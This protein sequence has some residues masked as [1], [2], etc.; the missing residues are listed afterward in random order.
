MALLNM[1]TA[2]QDIYT[3]IAAAPIISP[4]G[5]C[6]PRWFAADAAFKDPAELIITPDH[7]IFRMFYSQ[8]IPLEQLGVGVPE[9]E[10][11][12]RAIFHL[13]ARNWHLFLG[14]PTRLW[15]SHMLRHAFGIVGE[16]G[17]E[18]AD[19]IYDHIATCLRSFNYRPRA[20]FEAFKIE[21]LATTDA[22][23]DPLM[24]HTAIQA[25]R[26]SG[27]VIPTFR[28]DAVIDPL[29]PRFIDELDA[30]E[31]ISGIALDSY[32]DYLRALRARR[33]VFKDL[34]ATATDHAIEVLETAWLDRTEIET[35]W[36]KVRTGNDTPD[37]AQLFHAHML[38]EMAQMSVEDGLVMQIHAGS[39]RN[40]NPGLQD[41]FGRDMG[42]DI[43]VATDWTRGLETLLGRVGTTPGFRLVVFTLDE[44]AYARE[45]APM[46]GHWPCLRL[47]PPWWFH[48]SVAGIARF[49]DQ[50][51]ETAGYFNL[52]GFNDDTR[53]F[54]SI[55]ARHDLWRRGVAIHL[56]QQIER[57]YFDKTNADGLA[58]LLAVDL[59]RET[60]KLHKR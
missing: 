1:S 35:L 48:D 8:G 30:L 7:Y 32:S 4:H 53:A 39:R 44:S 59:A 40:T 52:A 60:Y 5:H 38:V 37:D 41:R 28:P 36:H 33:I 17:P 31:V 19:Q 42:A 29:D 55:P 50:V 9:N 26:W 56:A 58:Q 16:L 22:A 11:D 34:G 27:R 15:I 20:L 18:T 46:A 24:A 51:V 25:G 12:P 6:D 3:G 10:R 45:L 43:P 47:G 13:F 54:M 49:F 23:T 57:G 14:T 2:A 21:A